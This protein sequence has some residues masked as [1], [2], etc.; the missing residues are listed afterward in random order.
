MLSNVEK[1]N[2]SVLDTQLE[3]VKKNQQTTEA[4]NDRIKLQLEIRK[5]KARL[6]SDGNESLLERMDFK[7]N[8]SASTKE[9][10]LKLQ[11]MEKDQENRAGRQLT[12]QRDFLAVNKRDIRAIEEAIN[13]QSSS[14]LSSKFPDSTLGGSTARS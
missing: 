11:Q 4:A 6:R 2:K 9:Y 13:G 5:I 1:I 12:G 7:N 8:Y 10:M 14:Q 3:E